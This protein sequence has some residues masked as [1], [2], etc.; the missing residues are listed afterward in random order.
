MIV[1]S[2]AFPGPSRDVVDRM[3]GPVVIEFGTD[4]CGYCNGTAP[5]FE[6]V[7]DAHAGVRHVRVE[8]GSGRKL[9]RSFGVKLWPTFVFLRDGREVARLVRPRDAAAI[10]DAFARVTNTN[11]AA[12]P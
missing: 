9:G 12:R 11:L 6:A 3:P 7:R 1:Q 5:L 8:D 4:W 2:Y 10:R